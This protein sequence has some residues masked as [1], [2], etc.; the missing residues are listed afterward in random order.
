MSDID[1]QKQAV[2]VLVQHILAN[3]VHLEEA[4]KLVEGLITIRAELV[5]I[6][7][8]DLAGYIE[9]GGAVQF[10]ELSPLDVGLIVESGDTFIYKSKK[11]LNYRD[12]NPE[13]L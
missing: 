12:K 7:D 3:A 9:E 5:K 11:L 2:R 10:R 4:V 1:T 6:K 8:L 13:S